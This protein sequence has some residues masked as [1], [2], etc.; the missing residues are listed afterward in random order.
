MKETSLPSRFFRSTICCS[1]QIAESK[2]IR[3]REKTTSLPVPM[4][5]R[6]WWLVRVTLVVDW[7]FFA[8]K[9]WCSG[10]DLRRP[11][12]VLWMYMGWWFYVEVVGTPLQFL[13][14]VNFLC[15]Q[16]VGSLKPKH[17]SPPLPPPPLPPF[18]PFVP[19]GT[20]W[21]NFHCLIFMT[22]WHSRLANFHQ[23]LQ[24]KVGLLL[25]KLPRYI[26][27]IPWIPD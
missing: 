21:W 7:L 14:E 5:L 20:T 9:F 26:H 11:F 15:P 18:T 2:E 13:F 1:Y 27:Q 6:H 24:T 25:I 23:W 19:R 8:L 16:V 4:L 22:L 17:H 10:G 3:R 12:A